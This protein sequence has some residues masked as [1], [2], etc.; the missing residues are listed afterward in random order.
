MTGIIRGDPR[1]GRG[2]EARAR[3]RPPGAA[4]KAASS[5]VPRRRSSWATIGASASTSSVKP[6]RRIDPA[7]AGGRRDALGDERL[8]RGD[9]P[10]QAQL[11]LEAERPGGIRDEVAEPD[12]RPAPRRAHRRRPD[13]RRA[14]AA[15][16]RGPRTDLPG[17]RDR[18]QLRVEVVERGRRDERL[19][20]R[21]DPPDEMRAPL[22]I[23]LGEDVVEQQERRPAVER[24]QDVELGELEGQDRRPLLAARRE[25]REV[26]AVEL[27]DEVVAVRPDERRPVPDLLVGGLREPAG[28][29]VPRRL[30]GEWRGVGR[31]AQRQSRPSAASS[32]AISAWAAASGP[33]TTSSSRRR[34]ATIAPPAS[35]NA[36]SQKRSSSRD[37]PSSRIAR[38]RLL[39]CWSVRP[40]VASASA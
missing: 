20:Q 32:G 24:G 4:A 36:P 23:E 13:V 31:V 2:R 37:A 1:D 5:S 21:R 9:R 28:Q 3:R 22:G 18:P 38:S 30:P 29:G 17:R 26:A 19:R 27:E 10:R 34:S 6:S 7:G 12:H 8:E 14:R 35:R 11:V 15:P 40:Y 16:R 33:A 39:R 25:A